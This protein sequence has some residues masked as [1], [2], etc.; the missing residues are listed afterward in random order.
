MGR[1]V[2]VVW[3]SASCRGRQRKQHLRRRKRRRAVRTTSKSERWEHLS[4]C[5]SS[6]GKLCFSSWNWITSQSIVRSLWVWLWGPPYHSIWCSYVSLSSTMVGSTAHSDFSWIN[7]FA[8]IFGV[9]CQITDIWKYYGELTDMFK[10]K[11]WC[12]IKVRKEV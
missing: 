4:T 10:S 7:Y 5:L 2:F 8:L 6:V 3:P 12:K 1:T 11:R 9:Y